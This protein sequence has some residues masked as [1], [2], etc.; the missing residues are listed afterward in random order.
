VIGV[1]DGACR[2]PVVCYDR[3]CVEILLA[4]T[5]MTAEE[6]E[7]Y[8][9]FNELGAYV[10]KYTPLFLHDWQKESTDQPVHDLLER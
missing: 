10:G 6:A 1:V 7:E 3:K 9:E 5:E 8:L 2:E 4:T